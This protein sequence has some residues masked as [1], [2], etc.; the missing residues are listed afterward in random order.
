MKKQTMLLVTAMS[1]AVSLCFLCRL[2]ITA[3][4]W[5]L[6]LSNTQKAHANTEP[7]L[8]AP[9]LYVEDN[10]AKETKNTGTCFD[11]TYKITLLNGDN[12]CELTLEDYLIMVVMSE[13]SYTY[14]S[15]ALKAQAVSARTYALKLLESPGRHEKGTICN[16]AAHCSACLDECEYTSKYGSDAYSLAYERAKEAVN[17]TDGEVITY[18][19]ELCTAVYHASS[20]GTTENSY[21][22]WG[23]Y[24][25]YLLSVT[26]PEADVSSSV[27]VTKENFK[28]YAI[29]CGAN[30]FS[31]YDIKSVNTDS[32]RCD[33]I[34]L[35]GI[36]ISAGSLRSAFGLK[37]CD[38]TVSFDGENIIFSVQGYGHGIGMSQVGAN[39]MA[40][41]GSTYSQILL[42]YY[43]GVELVNMAV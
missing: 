16:S 31:C 11:K 38:F 18:N 43:T 5:D 26:T 15:E 33:F 40:K 1:I 9:I 42:H 29:A 3:F 36:N 34:E 27:V 7:S 21:N 39:T 41:A 28:S 10:E 23:T 24:T 25:P 32:G 12:A 17:A 30:D 20:Y 4:A 19:G 37:S 22:L 2:S 8:L 6:G 13:V 14:E 35:G